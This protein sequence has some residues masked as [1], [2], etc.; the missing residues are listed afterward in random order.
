MPKQAAIV[1][2]IFKAYA[3]ELE[4]LS[5]ARKP[6]DIAARKRELAGVIADQDRLVE[7][8]LS[9]VPAKR[10]KAPRKGL[11]ARPRGFEAELAR[12]VTPPP[13]NP[14]RPDLADAW[15]DRIRALV[16]SVSDPDDEGEMREHIRR[17]VEKVAIY[18]VP[19]SGKRPRPA[20][21]LYGALAQILRL[22]R[23]GAE[24]GPKETARIEAGLARTQL[25]ME[26]RGGGAPSD[27]SESPRPG[28]PRKRH[29]Q[30]HFFHLKKAQVPT[31]EAS[32]NARAKGYPQLCRS[33]GMFGKF[34]P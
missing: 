2:R 11:A 29:S 20:R 15:H 22:G 5:E 26:I 18:P 28:A 34:I 10:V 27:G 1:I 16:A 21:D 6:D 32:I 30:S 13:A 23:K 3:E 8:P 4:K 31:A 17:L 25:W 33:S 24:A 12:E 19:G 7:A 14:T 9:G